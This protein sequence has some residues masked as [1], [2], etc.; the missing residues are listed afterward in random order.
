M[1][2]P[3]YS[4]D[5]WCKKYGLEVQRL[6]CCKCE[7]YFDTTVPILIKGY[8]GLETPSHGC[9]NNQKAATFT[10]ISSKE[11]NEWNKIFNNM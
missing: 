10:P 5:E 9:E 7:K 4:L 3:E 1:I 2:Y 8:A 6:Q 11:I